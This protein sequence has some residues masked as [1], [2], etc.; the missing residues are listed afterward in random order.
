MF[1]IVRADTL[2]KLRADLD[3]YAQ[4][5]LEIRTVAA[6]NRRLRGYLH[7]A[8]R[9]LSGRNLRQRQ[10]HAND[11]TLMNQTIARLETSKQRLH[12]INHDLTL[13][14]GRWQARAERA[15][16]A[17]TYVENLA[18]GAETRPRN[19]RGRLLTYDQAIRQF[20]AE[21]DAQ[22]RPQ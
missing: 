13:E 14:N 6:H 21:W 15:M 3:Y 5:N 18:S 1:R 10:S 7:E 11:M 8:V 20:L 19:A 2:D 16:A 12:D 22:H 17:L 4:A 9:F